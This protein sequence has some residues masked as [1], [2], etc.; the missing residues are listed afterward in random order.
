M[1]DSAIDSFIAVRN[2]RLL[3]KFLAFCVRTG[4]LLHN[5]ILRDGIHHQVK[6]LVI[7]FIKQFS[8]LFQIAIRS[9]FPDYDFKSPFYYWLPSEMG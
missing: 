9:S 1:I 8:V 2:L 6:H 3:R 4:S 5:E 7:I